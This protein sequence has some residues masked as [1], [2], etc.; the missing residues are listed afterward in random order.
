MRQIP[1]SE[2]IIDREGRVY[3]LHLR[4]E[5]IGHTVLTVGDPSRVTRISRHF[6]RIDYRGEKREFVTHTGWYKDRR[7]TVLSTG[8]GPDN[9]DIAL[10]ELDALVNIDLETRMVKEEHTALNV[11]RVGTSGCIQPD[12]QV[13][14]ALISA[15]G[16]GLD[17][18]MAFYDYHPTLSEA[19]L[20]DEWRQFQE[21]T[22]KLPVNTYVVQANHPLLEVLGRNMR[23]GITF[24]APGF[25]GPQGRTLRAK[26]RMTLETLQ[27][28]QHF[29]YQGLRITNFEMETSAIYGLARML[30]HRAVSCNA[31]IAN[32]ATGTFSED[33]QA[34]VDQLILQVLERISELPA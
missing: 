25:Y 14:S 16:I 32:R 17:N 6:D 22:Q 28:I 3:H 20:Y 8:I 26:S 9:I 30:G 11:I 27:S 21:Y 13:D 23:S 10:N 4:P 5:D 18:L 24:T 7:I 2:L 34:A 19:T 15:F 31:I 12:I 33:P 29:S 1:D